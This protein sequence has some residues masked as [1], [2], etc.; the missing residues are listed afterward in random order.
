MLPS[1]YV[2]RFAVSL[3]AYIFCLEND[4][5]HRIAFQDI[6]IYIFCLQI[7]F[8]Y[9]AVYINFYFYYAL[10]HENIRKKGS[11]QTGVGIWTKAKMILFE[12]IQLTEVTTHTHTH[13]HVYTHMRAES[14]CSCWLCSRSQS[15]KGHEELWSWAFQASGPP[16]LQAHWLGS[17]S[18]VVLVCLERT[19]GP[20]SLSRT[21]FCLPTGV[22]KALGPLPLSPDSSAEREVGCG[23]EVMICGVPILWIGWSNKSRQVMFVHGSLGSGSHLFL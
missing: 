17:S 15:G 9:L 10:C 23:H 6:Y 19:Q 5:L 20:R 22:R 14:L 13:K 16:S 7:L 18:E 8:I 4:I 21:L 11:K 1:E 3:L 2:L 12:V